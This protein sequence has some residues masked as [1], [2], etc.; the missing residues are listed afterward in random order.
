[1]IEE[2]GKG[3]NKEYSLHCFFFCLGGNPRHFRE[4][5]L[6]EI[7]WMAVDPAAGVLLGVKFMSGIAT[8]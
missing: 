4:N 7:M 8:G 2:R 6:R 5:L 3:K 1:M